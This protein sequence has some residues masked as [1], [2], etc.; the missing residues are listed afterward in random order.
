VTPENFPLEEVDQQTAVMLM[1]HS[2][3]KDLNFLMIL[4]HIQCAYFGLLGPLKRREKLF[5]ALMEHSP[6]LSYDF[7]DHIHGPAGLNIGAETPQ[8]IAI[9]IMAEILSV[10]RNKEPMRLKNK[11]TG[12]HD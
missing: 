4:Q 2:Y 11:K 10:I 8:E 9:A 7:I 12:I 3:A 5:E 1:N 6:E